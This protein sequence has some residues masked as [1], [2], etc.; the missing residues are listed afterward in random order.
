MKLNK[1]G[2]KLGTV[3]GVTAMTDITGF[4]LLGHLKEMSEGSG[5]SAVIEFSKIPVIS[6]EIFTLIRE[7]AVPGGTG[8][9]L[10]SY[11][12]KIEV[13]KNLNERD[14]LQILADPQT[15]GGLLIAV[16]KDSLKEVQDLFCSHDLENYIQPI[17]YLTKKQKK[18][19]SII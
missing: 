12:E 11:Q 6:T 8:R 13:T 18:L 3:S 17:G 2:E 7:G 16:T 9:N 4:G 14:T 19:I 5:L 10:N 1:I 15:S